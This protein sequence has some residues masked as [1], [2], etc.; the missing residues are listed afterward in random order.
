MLTEYTNAAWGTH[1][2][3]VRRSRNGKLYGPIDK[4]INLTIHCSLITL[5]SNLLITF[6]L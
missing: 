4:S 6:N 5:N 3:L 2:E 1:G